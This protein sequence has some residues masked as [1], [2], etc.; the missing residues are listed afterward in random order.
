[1]SGDIYDFACWQG[2]LSRL[3]DAIGER[4]KRL[5]ELAGKMP[6][7]LEISYSE[8]NLTEKIL[9]QQE[10]LVKKWPI[11]Q[12]AL[13]QDPSESIGAAAREVFLAE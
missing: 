9:A 12:E 10:N 4:I 3:N 5:G 6:R 11:M 7:S 13:E 1:M 2:A 8:N